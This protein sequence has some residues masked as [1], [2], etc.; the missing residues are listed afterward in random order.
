MAIG[1][2]KQRL[3]ILTVLQHYNLKS[4]RNHQI[5]C[6]FHE[7]DKPSFRIYADTNTFH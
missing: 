3:S 6:P 5:K 1:D 2:I 7:D 4:D